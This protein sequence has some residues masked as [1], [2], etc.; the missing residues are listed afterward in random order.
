MPTLAIGLEWR[1]AIALLVGCGPGTGTPSYPLFIF[2]VAMV[3]AQHAAASDQDDGERPPRD[4][5][6][7]P[8]R[9]AAEAECQRTSGRPCESSEATEL[10]RERQAALA[11]RAR[12]APV[13]PPPRPIDYSLPDGLDR[14][15]ILTGIDHSKSAVA[16]CRSVSAAKG[17]VTVSVKV[18]HDGHVIAV[19]IKSTPEPALGEC[20]AAAL[21]TTTFAKTQR[22]GSFIYPF[23]F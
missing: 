6:T 17:R 23:E 12:L 14:T 18:A 3:V 2:D 13:E 11:R 20:V 19:S 22:G 21:H 16:A 1:I 10:R 15:S 9:Q 8:E 5:P 7:T 4:N